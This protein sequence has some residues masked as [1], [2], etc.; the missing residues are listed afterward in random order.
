MTDAVAGNWDWSM[1]GLPTACMINN[2]GT[3]MRRTKLFVLS[4]L[5]AVV[6][7]AVT[8]VTEA[9]QAEKRAQVGYLSPKSGFFVR[10]Y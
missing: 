10:R 9:Q 3:E 6:L 1:R 5:V 2:A 8:L 7:P 4:I